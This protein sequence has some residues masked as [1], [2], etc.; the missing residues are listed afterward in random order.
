MVMVIL[1]FVT[2]LL[3][4]A[5]QQTVFN[6]NPLHV[7]AASIDV[8]PTFPVRL[9]GYSNRTE[10]TGEIE[11]RL[12]AKALAISNAKGTTTSVLITVDAIGIPAWLTD[13]LAVRLEKR[14]EGSQTSGQVTRDS[15][16]VCATH[17]HAAPHL[18]GVLPFMFPKEESD[19]DI[20]A[21]RRY[22][23]ELLDKLELVAVAAL[24]DLEPGSL[25]WNR[26][27]VGF[28]VNRRAL[29]TGKWTGFG[30]QPDSPVDHSLPML[31]AK[32]A[33]GRLK[34]V[35]VT[36]AC[37]CTTTGGDLNRIHGDWAGYAQTEIE[38]RHP[39]ATAMVSIGCGADSNPN[40]RGE[41]ALARQYGGEVADEVDRLLKM[42]VTPIASAP[43]GDYQLVEI[44]FDP[45]P[46][47]A[48]WQKRVDAGGRDSR[49]ANSIVQKIDSGAPPAT[50][51]QY[52]IQTW[53]FGTDL[54]MVF[55]GGEVVVDYALH[56][57]R[58]LDADRLWVHG[59]SNDVPCYIASRRLYAE[60]GYEVDSSMTY[61]G[62]PCRLSIGT[63][64]R[65][66]D[67]VVGELSDEFPPR[68]AE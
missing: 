63:E 51:L 13:E 53:T 48:E 33:D 62:K 61:Y 26:G 22:T 4:P 19:E 34:A 60:G 3:L 45:I 28:A 12:R 31:Q 10:A 25:E 54:A 36:Y 32:A 6:E 11:H 1:A 47:R 58:K 67:A 24:E 43:E 46:S 20:K 17:T 7:G 57:R 50:S 37:H 27:S 41:L 56:L 21:S 23:D 30:V 29:K 8:T 2:A 68:K 64:D 39:G 66:V 49:F 9:S 16:A 55:L 59:Y 65:I 44:D 14:G 18:R 40:P 38:K 15:L 52:P 5:T 35:L 42:P